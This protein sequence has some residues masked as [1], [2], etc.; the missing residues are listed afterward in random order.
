[1]S[2]R[3]IPGVPVEVAP[4]VTR[5]V[6]PNPSM[7]TGPGTNSYVL[8]QAGAVV[9][10]PGPAI[11][12]HIEALQ[13]LAPAA[14]AVIVT[15]TH[16][17][18]SPAATDLAARTEALAL[19]RRA[20]PGPHQDARFAP[21]R[22]LA[23]GDRLE[24]D[25]VRLRVL[26]TPGHASNHLCFLRES[27][28]LLFTGDHIINGST[29]VIDP[30][31]GDMSAYLDSL[32]RLRSEGVRRIAPGHGELLDEPRAAIDWLI[33]HRLEREASV[34]AALAGHP[35]VTL[36]ELTRIVYAE[37]DARLHPVA[38]RSLLA[39]LLKLRD[40]RRAVVDGERWRLVGD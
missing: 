30:P 12:R 34:A 31:D 2:D 40:E 21:D 22:E 11:G 9:I 10:D 3:L 8:G 16:R 23:D 38:E 17:D 39:H 32:A 1:M 35:A 36:A 25:D 26:H 7:M 37:V 13:G 14:R 5:L 15:H 20:P 28:G 6:A 27:D 24:F 18:H 29:V 4:G 33:E 19:G